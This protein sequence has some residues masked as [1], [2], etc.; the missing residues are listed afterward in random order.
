MDN[1]INQHKSNLDI[2]LFIPQKSSLDYVICH[3]NVCTS[4][5]VMD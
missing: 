5:Y 1:W 4:Q 3:K 2:M